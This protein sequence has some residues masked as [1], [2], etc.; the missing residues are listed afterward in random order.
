MRNILNGNCRPL[1]RN[2]RIYVSNGEDVWSFDLA[3]KTWRSFGLPRTNYLLYEANGSLWAIYGKGPHPRSD[4]STDQGTGLYRIDTDKD[5]AELIFST[6]RRPAEHPLDTIEIAAP[7]ALF[8]GT[9]GMPVIGLIGNGKRFLN[10]KNGT[11]WTDAVAD[12]LGERVCLK[13]QALLGQ[14]FNYEISS[15]KLPLMESLLAVDGQG[16][17][18]VLLSDPR[19]ENAVPPR[20][21]GN[22]VWKIPESLNAYPEVGNRSY[23]PA[24]VGDTLYVLIGDMVGSTMDF[25]TV[26]ELYVFERGKS[27]P[28]RLP[29]IFEMTEA[30]RAKISARGENPN[31][32]LNPRA[33]WYGF[34]AS[35]KG[36]AV[37]CPSGFWFIPMEDVRQAMAK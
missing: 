33:V 20:W 10:V 19:V 25:T 36:L 1:F 22:A 4:P 30:D 7:L 18:E 9:D 31:R 27:E 5:S 21:S 23:C 2:G 28:A 16:R 11:A 14:R 34:L 32:D 6:R 12:W 15:R 29:V 13:G 37:T 8:S 26:M 3:S 24:R 17:S 35:E